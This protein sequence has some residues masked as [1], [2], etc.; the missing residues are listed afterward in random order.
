MGTAPALLERRLPC[1]DTV[2]TAIVRS[3][4][5][6]STDGKT[7]MQDAGGQGKAFPN[8]VTLVGAET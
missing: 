3:S 1:R 5:M 2:S 4:Q 7:A 6:M 8:Q